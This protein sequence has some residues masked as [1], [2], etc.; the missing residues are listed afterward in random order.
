MCIMADSVWDKIYNISMVCGFF[1]CLLDQ[2][3]AFEI[4]PRDHHMGIGLS[5]KSSF[6]E[7]CNWMAALIT[8]QTRR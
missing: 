8:L 2:K 4:V 6:E 3:N 5:T 7:K 1:V